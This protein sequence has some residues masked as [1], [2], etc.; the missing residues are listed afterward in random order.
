MA[1]PGVRLPGVLSPQFDACVVAYR[2]RHVINI[3]SAPPRPPPECLGSV[4]PFSVWPLQD[5][6]RLAMT[7]RGPGS[8]RRRRERRLRSMLRHERQTVAMEFRAALH[9]SRDVGTELYE[10]LRAQTTASSGM[11]PAPLVEVSEPQ[12]GQSR[13]VSWLP[14]CRP[15]P[16]PFWQGRQVRRSMI[17]PSASSS[18]GRLPSRRRRRR[19]GGRRRWRR[20]SRG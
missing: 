12:G 17:S 6:Q 14:R 3:S 19:S 8:A 13:S 4:F 15:S 2:Q 18:G 11:R 5:L 10:G 20:R 7:D 1:G 16:F 9:H